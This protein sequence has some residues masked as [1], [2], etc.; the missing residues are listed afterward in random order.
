[1]PGLA[2]FD[3][4]VFHRVGVTFDTLPLP[5]DLRDRILVS[6]IA[7]LEVLSHLTLKKGE[8][9]MRR[10]QAIRNWLNLEHV[11]LLPWPDAAI[12]SIAFQVTPEDNSLTP[13]VEHTVNLCLNA[14]SVEEIRG[15]ARKL[16][17]ALDEVKKTNALQF[18]HLVDGC[19]KEPLVG[20]RFREVWV[21]AKARRAGLD[22]N[23]RPAAEVV[24]ALSAYY[25]FEE[26]TLRVA[27]SNLSYD[28]DKHKNDLLDCEQL[29][30]LGDPSL[31]FLTCDGGFS[32]RIKKSDQRRR[33][34][35]VSLETLA[36]AEKTEALLR[37]VTG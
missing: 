35:R 11:R 28:P 21:S 5:L 33:I 13:D 30:Y 20:D 18:K 1:M 19:R 8:E 3:A 25:E 4:D 14:N 36:D 27:V 37:A 2:Y 16:K 9:V 26:Q 15:S 23:T 6:P 31:H 29:V 12:S 17:D 22:E 7:T 24:A 34:H 32:K 10:I